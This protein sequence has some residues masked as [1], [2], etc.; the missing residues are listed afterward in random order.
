MAAIN[1]MQDL[2]LNGWRYPTTPVAI[3]HYQSTTLGAVA[4]GKE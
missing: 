1:R 3:V 4:R 2:E